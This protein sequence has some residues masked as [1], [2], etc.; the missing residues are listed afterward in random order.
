MRPELP[1]ALLS[2]PLPHPRWAPG[3][4]AGLP[5]GVLGPGLGFPSASDQW[6]RTWGGF[7]VQKQPVLAWRG[8]RGW[9]CLHRGRDLPGAWLAAEPGVPTQDPLRVHSLCPLPCA[10][11][12]GGPCQDQVQVILMMSSQGDRLKPGPPYCPRTLELTGCPCPWNAV[13]PDRRRGVGPSST[14]GA[15]RNPRRDLKGPPHL[16]RKERLRAAAEGCWRGGEWGRQD[17]GSLVIHGGHMSERCRVC[18]S[19]GPLADE[20]VTP[21]QEGG[22]EPGW[23]DAQGGRA[24]RQTPPGKAGRVCTAPACQAL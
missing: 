13:S 3:A 4:R 17:S 22:A 8:L 1:T 19:P 12:P 16:T 15:G 2:T 21:P 14:P 7:S 18:A 6:P 9:P 23:S 24:S 20:A 5:G 10:P 11:L